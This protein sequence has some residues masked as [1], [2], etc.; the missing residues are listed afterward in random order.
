[1]LIAVLDLETNVKVKLK[2]CSPVQF[3]VNHY[4]SRFV[5]INQFV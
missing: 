2:Y 1:M 4:I 3:V 5:C